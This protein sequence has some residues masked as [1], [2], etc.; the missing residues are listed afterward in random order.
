M[1][2]RSTPLPLA[3][4]EARVVACRRCVRLRRYC[5]EIARTK[6][7]AY[8]DETYWGLPVPG[9]G[10][11]QARMLVLGLAP[12]A[13]GANRTGRMFT[14]DSSGTFLMRAL[15]RAGFASAP[16]S[17]RA[18]DGLHLT[19]AFI[20]AAARCAPPDN[21]PAPDELG[22]CL[23][24]L[25]AETRALPRLKVVVALGRVAFDAWLALESRRGRHHR[26]KPEFGHAAVHNLGGVTSVVTSYHP[27][28]Q[29]TNTGRLTEA[30]FDEVFQLAR[31][32]LETQDA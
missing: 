10:D 32:A 25:D 30:M 27:S 12:A 20:S 14:G 11:P 15:H 5:L 17:E 4:V 21:K 16:A 8:R 18:D 24:H 9:F 26:P 31:R 6:K 1:N 23:D 29:N 19:D 28:R 3:D 7:A 22:A 13:H 2:Q